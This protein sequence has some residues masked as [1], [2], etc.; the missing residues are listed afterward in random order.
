MNTDAIAQQAAD[1]RDP[2]TR[3]PAHR[4]S[5]SRDRLPG[6][7]RDP[8]LLVLKLVWIAGPTAGIQEPSAHRR[9]DREAREHH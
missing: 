5:P 8:A 7:R 3:T 1:R 4:P 6:H 2:V 9:R